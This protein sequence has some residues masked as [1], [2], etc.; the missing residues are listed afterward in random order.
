VG[1]GEVHIFQL[2]AFERFLDLFSPHR[3]PATQRD[4]L[5]NSHCRQFKI[6]LDIVFLVMGKGKTEFTLVNPHFIEKHVDHG[7][8]QLGQTQAR[9][10]HPVPICHI[11]DINF[12]HF[13][14][15][16]SVTA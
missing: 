13:V 1:N 3:A 16:F 8:F 7:F 15:P 5:Q 14:V 11:N 6:G 10:L 9:G 12:R 2:A 4:W